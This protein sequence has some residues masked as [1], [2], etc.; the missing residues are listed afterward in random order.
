[1]NLGYRTGNI[2]IVRAFTRGGGRQSD[3]HARLSALRVLSIAQSMSMWQDAVCCTDEVG[4][5]GRADTFLPFPLLWRQGLQ[6]KL[7]QHSL[8]IKTNRDYFVHYNKRAQQKRGGTEGV[9]RSSKR[10]GRFDKGSLGGKGNGRLN[11]H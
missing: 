2:V 8:A 4:R 9:E 11:C 6:T 1:M 7:G 10:R 5:G 3:M